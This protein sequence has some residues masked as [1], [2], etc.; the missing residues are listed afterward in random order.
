MI[1]PPSA[2]GGD[3]PIPDNEVL[4]LADLVEYAGK[5][6]TSGSRS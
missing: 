5:P 3:V 2:S 6:Q 1:D 4:A